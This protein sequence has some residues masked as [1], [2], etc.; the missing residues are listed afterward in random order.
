MGH[1]RQPSARPRRRRRRAGSAASGGN[2]DDGTLAADGDRD[3]TGIAARRARGSCLGVALSL[4][5]VLEHRTAAWLPTE[6]EKVSALTALGISKQVLPHRL[7]QGA[8]GA[9]VRYFPRSLPVALDRERAN[10][11]VRADPGRDGE[12]GA[13]VGLAALGAVSGAGRGRLLRSRWSSS[14]VTRCVWQ[15]QGGCSTS[16]RRRLPSP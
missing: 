10:V 4:D 9:Q 14:A 11:P 15:R 8:V 13:H 2:V 5:I 1:L 12:R 6:D 3:Q 7:Y 16:G